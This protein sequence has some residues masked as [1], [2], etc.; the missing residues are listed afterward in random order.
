[1]HLNIPPNNAPADRLQRLTGANHQ[2]ERTSN[3]S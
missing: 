1:M 2:R 3:G